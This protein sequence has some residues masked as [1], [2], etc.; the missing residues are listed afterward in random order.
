MSKRRT[1]RQKEKAK[2]KFLYQPTD[3]S[4][5]PAVKGQISKVKKH[6]KHEITK[7]KMAVYTEKIDDLASI[8]K[9]I[10]KSVILASLILSLELV[11]Y[12]IWR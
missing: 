11:I 6:E 7:D 3:A 5:E 9:N 4:N 2:H 12:L 10:G 1:R 8:K